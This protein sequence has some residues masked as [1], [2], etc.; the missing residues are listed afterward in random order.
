MTDNEENK[1]RR[2]FTYEG[3]EYA[4][5]RPTPESVRTANELRSR[6][7]NEALQRGDLLRDQLDNEL[8]K[9]E[10]W[11]DSSEE[12]YQS[13]RKKIV[14]GEYTLKKGGIKLAEA[15]DIALEM[16]KARNTMIE[17]LSGRSE[18]DSNTCEGKADAARF[19]AL[20]AECLVYNENDAKFFEGGYD[21]YMTR[22]DDPVA[23]L[24]ATEFFYL[25]SGSENVDS[26][27]PENKFLQSYKFVDE[28]YRLIDKD[29]KLVDFDGN[30]IDE[31]GNLIEWISEDEYNYVDITGRKVTK[32]GD[33]DI[34]FVP[35]LDDSGKPVE[36]AEEKPEEEEEEEANAEPEEKPAPKKRRGRPKKSQTE[37]SPEAAN[38]AS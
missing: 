34:D 4:V 33:W 35:F 6:T 37:K 31:N 26:K 1:D 17:M 12:E 25:V 14:D 28:K 36:S 5:R 7:F 20:F 22:Q 8:R 32:S 29:G 27:L 13:L 30:H 23:V 16:S 21:E 3:A 19:N 11:N 24:G 9:R 38:Q 18:L 15:K 2:V 10:L